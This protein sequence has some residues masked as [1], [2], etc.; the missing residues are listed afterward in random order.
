MMKYRLLIFDFDGTLADSFPLFLQIANT[1]ADAHTLRRIEDHEIESLRG[2]DA[3]RIIQHLGIPWWKMPRVIRHV[4]RLSAGASDQIRLFDGADR[5]L[6]RLSRRGVMLAIV[7]SNSYATVRRALGPETAALIQHY[8]CDVSTFGKGSRFRKVVKASGVPRAQ[9]L[10]IGDEIRDIEA[11]NKE[12]IPFGAVAWGFN[13]IEALRAY[14][15]AE[16]FTSL[17]DIVD[18][19]A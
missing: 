1:V 7:T 9:S 13:H 19:V 18:V 16:V 11:A 5:M 17:D 4:R 3:R 14:A 6:H 10:A 2:Y 15:P 8:E 12:Q